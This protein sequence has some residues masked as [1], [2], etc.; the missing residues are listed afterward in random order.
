[1]SASPVGFAAAYR[2]V[3]LDPATPEELSLLLSLVGYEAR[4]AAIARWPLEKRVEAEVYAVNVHLRAS[5]NVLRRC[6][7]PSWLTEPWQGT[8]AGE[9]VFEGPGGT[10][11]E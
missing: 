5:D 2:R 9:G 7:R 1:M 3:R 8:P 11:V 6:P 10:V 4:P